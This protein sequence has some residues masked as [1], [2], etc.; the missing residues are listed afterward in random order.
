[1]TPDVSVLIPCYRVDSWLE[2]ALD[3]I[4]LASSSL[5]VELLIIANNMDSQQIVALT[6]TCKRILLN[7]FKILDAGKV[8]LVGA[9]N[10]GIKKCSSDL[11]ARMDQDDIMHPERLVYQ[12]SF[13]RSNHSV[14]L[15]GANVEIID[16]SGNHLAF[17]SYPQSN[18]EIKEQLLFGNCFAHPV[19]MYRKSAIE[20]IGLYNPVFTQAEDF[21]M[22]TSIAEKFECINLQKVLL[23]Y[24]INDAQTSQRR[25][26]IQELST[27]AIILKSAID[28]LPISKVLLLPDSNSELA[29]WVKSIYSYI[30]L[31]FFS[32]RK[33]ERGAARFLLSAVAR[34]HIA[35]ARSSGYPGNRRVL[36]TIRELLIAFLCN[37]L[38]TLKW[39]GSK[40]LRFRKI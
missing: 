4:R 33:K 8:D 17:Q 9:L 29:G 15:V 24:R 28:E 37:P 30:I 22:Y 32:V 39:L 18:K 38:I 16:S 34:S 31:S 5:N 2:D 36:K 14:S 27:R 25:R 19:V 10:F 12:V 3:S 40:V 21:A 23:K 26:R 7:D 6:T 11:I 35:I 1:M 20:A 13:L